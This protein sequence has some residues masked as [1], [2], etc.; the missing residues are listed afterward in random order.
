MNKNMLFRKYVVNVVEK[1]S[2]R[3]DMV[4]FLAHRNDR[5]G[6][7]PLYCRLPIVVIFRICFHR[8]RL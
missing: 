7:T 1:K 6:I 4:L 3:K 8:Y 5:I 2:L